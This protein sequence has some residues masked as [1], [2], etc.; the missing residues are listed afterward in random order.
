MSFT[1]P[2]RSPQSKKPTAQALSDFFVRPALALTQSR[3]IANSDSAG[4]KWPSKVVAR[5]LTPANKAKWTWLIYMAGDNNLEAFGAANIA[6]MAKVGSTKDVNIIVQF[7]AERVQTR[8]YRIEK[9]SPR[10]LQSMPN[11]NS[12]IPKSLTQFLK[13]GME[14]FPADRFVVVAWNHGG[15]WENVDVDWAR[16]RSVL[17]NQVR[18]VLSTRKSLF[19]TTANTIAGAPDGAAR[20]ILIDTGSKTYL[21]NQQFRRALEGISRKVDILGCDACL[22]NML[23]IAYEMRKT[24]ATMVGSEQLEP[25]DGW[26]YASILQSLVAKPTMA[27]NDLA[28][29]IVKSYGTFY[30]K[31][32]SLGGAD[33]TTLS[34]FAL[35]AVKTVCIALDVLAAALIGQLPKIAGDIALARNEVLSFDTHD[36]V[37]L[38][39][40]AAKFIARLKTDPKIVAAAKAL[41]KQL[42]NNSAFVLANATSGKTM[43]RAGGVSIYFPSRADAAMFRDYQGLQFAKDH[44]WLT[45]LKKFFN[46]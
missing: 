24:A 22:M 12:G 8:R 45:F 34:A 20:L 26:P 6:E 28:K 35:S 30:N 4:M 11:V 19:K 36:Y 14:C 15:G 38:D 5:R 37:D 46:S 13:W 40:L 43:S 10:L 32:P 27:P 1:R 29:L 23:E 25:G 2:R 41:R 42:A 39:D 9:R 16:N 31:H 44:K 18:R 17:P 3:A 21:D 33:G 7:D